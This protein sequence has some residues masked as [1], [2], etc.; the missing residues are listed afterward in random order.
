[1]SLY[2]NVLNGQYMHDV[3]YF[4]KA[5]SRDRK[6]KQLEAVTNSAKV[7]SSETQMLNRL[8]GATS[9]RRVMMIWA[10]GRGCAVKGA[11]CRKTW[12]TFASRGFFFF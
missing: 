9:C 1:M 12:D 11:I 6:D 4:L 3:I 2:E 8:T 7:F 10:L 5:E